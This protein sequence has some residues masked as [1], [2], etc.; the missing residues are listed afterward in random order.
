MKIL[1][2]VE[3]SSDLMKHAIN[4]LNPESP[5]SAVQ[6][7]HS[8]KEIAE[9]QKIT[10]ED[11]RVALEGPSTHITT[12]SWTLDDALGYR[13][14][15][16]AIARFITHEQTGKPLCISIHAPWGGGKTSLMRMIQD[17]LDP[18]A[19][20]EFTSYTKENTESG[21]KYARHSA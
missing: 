1:E 14:Y 12:D 11:I 17:K 2:W 20:K 13:A 9:H 19:V 5:S 21:A 7:Q 18:M 4:A 3:Y 16:H 6:S 15:A 10:E 8:L